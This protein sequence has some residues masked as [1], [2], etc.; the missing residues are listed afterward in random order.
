MAELAG[1]IADGPMTPELLAD[2]EALVESCEKI[3]TGPALP[4]SP[5]S[6]P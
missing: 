1:V 3:V 2:L 4:P 6:S 5:E